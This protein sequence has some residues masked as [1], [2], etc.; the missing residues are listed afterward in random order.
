MLFDRVAPEFAKALS[1]ADQVVLLP[2]YPAR[3][4]PIEGVT[5]ELIFKDLTA[6]EKL[7]IEKEELMEWLGEEYTDVLVTFG[8]GNIDRYVTPIAEMLK[9]R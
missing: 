1:L 3:E 9:D 4:E 8:A 6:P 2:I 7:L 5:S